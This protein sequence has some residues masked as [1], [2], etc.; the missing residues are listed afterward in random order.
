MK[1]YSAYKPSGVEWIGDIPEKWETIKL[2]FLTSYNDEV[3]PEK[4]ND[5][6]IINYVEISDVNCSEGV[7]N[8]T[9]YTFKDA[10]S[11]ARRVTK[12]NDV[13]ISTVRTYLKAIAKINED[14]L[15]VSTGFIVLRPQKVHNQFLSYGALSE[16]FISDVIS[17][18]VGV[19]YPA[20]NASQIVNIKIPVPSY[21]EQVA[22]AAYLD[23]KCAKIDNVLSVQQKRI[24]LL[25]ELKQSIITNAV[26][27]GLD[28]NVEFKPSGIEWIGDIPEKWTLM[29][30]KHICKDEKY[31]IKTGPFGSQLK[32][33]D[34]R[35]E[36]DVRVYNQRNVI[37]DCFDDVQFFVTSAKAKDLQ[38]FFT[39]ENDL[40]VTSRGTIGKCSI[41]PKT[42]PMGVLHPCLIALRI[43]EKKC[44]LRWAKF[45]INESDCF[46]TNV[47]LNSN[48]TTIEVIYT[49][50]LKSI[51]I[52]L[53]PLKEQ[54][55][56][57]S[58]LEHKC[59]AIDSQISKIERQIEL[60]KE[61]KQS[62]ITECVTGKRK[63]C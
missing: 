22:I 13:I 3:L 16:S 60:L 54:L 21:A 17:Q 1:R 55:A 48:A 45:F 42:A 20:I 61:Y 46:K 10:P 39:K 52:P 2:K 5:N 62:I 51:F 28:K 11:R 6:H 8:T 43:N 36:G 29:K 27:K 63:V 47:F 23:A 33:E 44:S 58:Y 25:K 38:S 15:I 34:L 9:E 35:E 49:D 32:G 37:D 24:E 50:T 53:P 56:I 26:T 7:V 31:S 41:L 19:S 14:V 59:S 12:K 4:T 30:L 18:S 40:L 57:I